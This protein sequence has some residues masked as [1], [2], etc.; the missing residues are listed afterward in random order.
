MP[1]TSYCA[2]GFV[3]HSSVLG[4]DL[5]VSASSLSM[6]RIEHGELWLEDKTRVTNEQ[7]MRHWIDRECVCVEMQAYVVVHAIGVGVVLLDH[8]QRTHESG[9]I[10]AMKLRV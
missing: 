8:G 1:S 7:C 2:S 6:D 9:S 4:F 3:I 5:P 10:N